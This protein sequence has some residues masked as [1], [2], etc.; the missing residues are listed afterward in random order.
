MLSN[1]A[2]SASLPIV[3]LCCL[4]FLQ[5][6][7]DPA[8]RLNDSD[9]Q[10]V[11]ID[12]TQD[13]SFLSVNV[14]S[15]GRV[16]AGARE[17]L[18]VYEPQA[19]GTYSKRNE[20]YR[21][22]QH[23]W[24]YDVAFRGNDL[25]VMTVTALYLLPNARVQRNDITAKPLLWGFPGGSH[26]KPTY[27]VHQGLHGLAWGPE[28]DLYFSFGDLAWGVGDFSRPDHWNFI[29]VY[30]A[31]GKRIPFNGVGGIARIKPDGTGFRMVADGLRN[32]CGLEFDSQWNL[33]S[34]DNDHESRPAQFV[35]GR[36]LYVTAGAD[37]A[38]PRG[39]AL[40]KTPQR[41]DLLKTMSE[42]MGRTVPVGQTY[43]DEP[44]LPAE[45]RNNI[46]LARWGQ[47][48]LERY[49]V[50]PMGAT[51][52]ADSDV[53]LA[54]QGMARPVGVGVG[55][56][57]RIFAAICYMGGNDKSPIYRSELVMITRAD[58]SDEHPFE[59]TDLVK[60]DVNQLFSALASP[61]RE[62]R[63]AAHVEC[64]RRHQEGLWDEQDMLFREASNRL[65]RWFDSGADPAGRNDLAH[66]I[67]LAII[68][69]PDNAKAKLT[70]ALLSH[71]SASVRLQAV[72]AMYAA[73]QTD[74]LESLL[75][76]SDHQVRHNAWIAMARLETTPGYKPN[77]VD[78]DRLS[79]GIVAMATSND[80]YLRQ[81]G[82][83]MIATYFD[84]ARLAKLS[85]AGSQRE[86]LAATMALGRRLTWPAAD[87]VPPMSMPLLEP[88]GPGMY[89]GREVIDLAK[90]ARIG[91]Y[92]MGTYWKHV[93]RTSERDAWF[94]LLLKQTADE[95]EAVRLHT[96]RY[97]AVLH[98]RRSEPS[99]ARVWNSASI[100]RQA[101]A[102]AIPIGAAWVLGGFED[103]D[104]SET[105]AEQLT[106][107]PVNLNDSVV[108]EGAKYTWR[109]SQPDDGTFALPTT[110]PIS[111]F[112]FQLQ[113]SAQQ[114][115][116]LPLHAPEKPLEVTV[117]RNGQLTGSV[118]GHEK[119]GLLADKNI[120]QVELLSGT[121]D[122]IVRVGNTS[123]GDQLQILLK[124]AERV[125]IHLPPRESSTLADRLKN[126]VATGVERVVADEF[127]SVNWNEA[128]EQ[129]DSENGRRLFTSIGCA[130]CH[131]VSKEFPVDG[132]PS[133]VGAGRRFNAD[134]L[135]E[136]ILAPSRRINELFQTKTIVTA[137]GKV[138]SG[139][140]L[141]NTE[142]TLE[143]LLAD[144]SRV[145]IEKEEVDS[146][147]EGTVSVM[148]TGLVKTPDELKDILAY[149]LELNEE[150]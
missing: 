60:A 42:S 4:S 64:V 69:D 54:G 150:A 2:M 80:T 127:L 110:G 24:I 8:Y 72:R 82:V 51:F 87:F 100:A 149:L 96:A 26:P 35:P 85:E 135:V 30:T 79:A 139:L 129:G 99:I 94:H 31:D 103:D 47:R 37:F 63:Y 5:A 77:D 32:P 12:S 44:Y 46:L 101:N 36:L 146:L 25:Y 18:F 113:S 10:L 83:Q 147:H 27:G 97:L 92:T 134:Y 53:L 15:E 57:G 93:P 133:L 81:Y 141:A 84:D 142:D 130:K 58:D 105:L 49:R 86:R 116:G 71:S 122:I 132:G 66:L 20:L 14:D 104:E 55:R 28:G 126:G 137:E 118:A 75:D 109:Q 16:F 67:P 13:E 17:A 43:Y 33:F 145:R 9:L 78:V 52:R 114:V 125:A 148:P 11:M 22:P 89:L 76:D 106:S 90:L 7:E 121:N 91:N 38:W 62:L 41:K 124:A 23:T 40:F 65:S 112:Y 138:I 108:R 88:H 45:Y 70:P 144:A 102:P 119:R 143:V 74:G 73:K 123:A 131:A 19:D 107:R 1:G 6:A 98:D 39:W 21:F 117:W 111:F 140:V 128:V 120:A 59:P 95:S 29:Y 61:S 68:A 136:S 56:G 115:V 48:S 34:H 3:S 50:S